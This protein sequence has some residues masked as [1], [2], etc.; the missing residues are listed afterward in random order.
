MR[1]RVHWRSEAR[2]ARWALVA[3]AVAWEALE[4]VHALR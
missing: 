4:L 1:L 3:A 2:F